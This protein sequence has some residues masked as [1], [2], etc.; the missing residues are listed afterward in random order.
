VT[1]PELSPVTGGRFEAT[2][3]RCLKHSPFIA[4]VDAAHAWSDLLKIGWS[5]ND[6]GRP[7]AICPKCTA[8]P[9]TI[10]DAAKAA[11]KRRKKK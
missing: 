9:E 4:A 8:N 7:C 3:G 11:Q 6:K 5:V 2:C 1:V 10:D